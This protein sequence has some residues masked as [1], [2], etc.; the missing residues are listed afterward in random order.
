MFLGSIGLPI[1]AAG[2][3]AAATVSLINVERVANCKNI[4]QELT[5]DFNQRTDQTIKL[6]MEI[7]KICN[8]EEVMKSKLNEA[9][10]SLRMMV[11]QLTKLK[12]LKLE[13]AKGEASSSVELEIVNRTESRLCSL[14]DWP[15]IDQKSRR[16][17]FQDVIEETLES[18]AELKWSS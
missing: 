12:T 18:I 3:A 5:K 11:D 4:S 2:T 9:E 14:Q 7:K 6:S 8:D 1:A 17:M 15:S 16:K 13:I 10:L